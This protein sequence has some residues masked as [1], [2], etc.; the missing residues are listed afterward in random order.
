MGMGRCAVPRQ[1][2]VVAAAVGEGAAPVDA[3]MPLSGIRMVSLLVA[4]AV[5]DE[6]FGPPLHLVQ[7]G[8]VA[9]GTAHPGEWAVLHDGPHL[10]L[11]QLCEAI[12]V[13]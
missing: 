10:S 3:G 13:E 5:I 7:Q 12:C 9:L 2:A 1:G 4:V 6:T 11:V 8:E